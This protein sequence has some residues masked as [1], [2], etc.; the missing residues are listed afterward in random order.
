MSRKF[1]WSRP[2]REIDPVRLAERLVSARPEQLHAPLPRPDDEKAR[3]Q[4]LRR[5]Y[6]RLRRAA[7][8][9]PSMESYYLEQAEKVERQ[10][11][12]NLCAPLTKPASP[13]TH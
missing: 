3:E 7:R 1:N 13:P 8:L 10:I 4:H 11:E 5:H 9:F 6:W 2:Y 12:A